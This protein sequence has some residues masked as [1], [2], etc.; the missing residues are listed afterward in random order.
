M[1]SIPPCFL[2]PSLAALLCYVNCITTRCQPQKCTSTPSLILFLSH[3]LPFLF[4]WQPPS[5]PCSTPPPSSS[6]ISGNN[7]GHHSSSHGSTPPP[8]PPAQTLKVEAL[9][10]TCTL[11]FFF[12]FSPSCCSGTLP[13]SSCISHPLFIPLSLP[14]ALHSP[15]GLI[16]CEG[17]CLVLCV[18][19]CECI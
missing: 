4:L 10:L 14:A 17:G 6:Q 1:C 8:H 16:R 19:V 15:S 11:H 13:R 5:P 12:Y 9:L 7:P 2:P 3:T 18:F